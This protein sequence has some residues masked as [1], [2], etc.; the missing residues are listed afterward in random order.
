M[1]ATQPQPRPLPADPLNHL[2]LGA[3]RY[4]SHPDVMDY[5]TQWTDAWS[6]QEFRE[7]AHP[8]WCEINELIDFEYSVEAGC[9]AG[10]PVERVSVGTPTPGLALLHL[11]GGMFCVGTPEIDRVLN[12]PIARAT[13]VEVFSP[14]YRL[15]PEHPFPAAVE[16]AVACY[17][18]LV[19]QGNRVAIYGESAGGG[20]AAACTIAVRDTGLPAPAALGLISPILDLTGG[21][22]T[23]RTMA[24]NDPDYF[25]T[26]ALLAPAAAYAANTPLDEPLVS[27]VYADLTGLPPTMIQVGSREVLLGDSTRFARAAR[28]ASVDVAL[29]V[30]DGGWHNY[31]IWYGV[32]EA[33]DAVA[34]MAA[35]LMKALV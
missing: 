35:F 20:L 8:Q 2:S 25:D 3:Q 31:P 13:G 30:L 32:P 6:V 7:I 17:R 9:I 29:D 18:W 26:S 24:P 27:P 1:L 33:D 16:D 5:P 11:H 14:D 19:E 34:A 15:A 10:V 21:S 12:A 23:Y 4:L 28:S 22:D